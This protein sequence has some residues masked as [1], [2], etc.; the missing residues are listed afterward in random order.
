MIFDL[1]R[2]RVALKREQ[3]EFDI[4]QLKIANTMMADITTRRVV[5]DPDAGNWIKHG[6][7]GGQDEL[8]MID[9]INYDHYKM[10]GVVFEKYHSDL[11]CRAIVRTMCKFVLGKGPIVKAKDERPEVQATWDN[12]RKDNKWSLREKE[13][14]RRVFRD[15]EVFMRKFTNDTGDMRVRFL[16]ADNIR[17]PISVRDMMQGENVSYGVG[18]DPQDIENVQNYYHC[19]IDGTLIER[20]PAPEIIHIK[21]LSDSDMK[22]G[23]SFLLTSLPMLAK[24]LSW[25]DDRIALNK[26]RS[27][28]A[29]I[30]QVEG[31]AN[32][33]DNIRDLRKSQTRSGS[34][35]KQQMPER[36]TV[37]T[38]NK[39]ISYSMLSPNIN[40]SDVKDDGRSMLL[41]VAAGCG[42][43]EM[44]LTAD[45]AN[46]NYSSTLVAQNP[47]VR[48]IEDWQ[49]FFEFY[50]TDLFSD[51]VKSKIKSGELP[52]NCNT[53][54]NIEWPPLILAD[55][56]KNN[57]SREIQHRNKIISKM[58]WQLKEG[59]DPEIEE[60]NMM[61]ELDKEVY[62]TPFNLP[63]VPAN[64]Y[65]Q[66]DEDEFEDVEEEAIM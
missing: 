65:G 30:K 51:V 36:A 60:A 6:G 46:A 16:R 7:S 40:A 19:K 5:E 41:A 26:V 10:L 17:N 21:I 59:L 25:L 13:M 31:T 28:I 57:K 32:T 15:G 33:I 63:N 47:F 24:Y 66:W 2:K 18:T 8:S 48:E 3:L 55:I 12:F 35:N 44:F 45:Y 56:E 29:L 58:T 22:R 37:I 27:A 9:V 54:C 50:Y 49:D 53:N 42:F 1:Y 11:Y 62:R 43:P 64:Q 14:V 39:G 61:Q 4:N 23:I 52:E 34:S 38:A 20:I